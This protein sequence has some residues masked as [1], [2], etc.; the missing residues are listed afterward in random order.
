MAEAIEVLGPHHVLWDATGAAPVASIGYTFDG[1]TIGHEKFWERVV[2]D[3]YG[4]GTSRDAV[5]CGE[6][7]FIEFTLHQVLRS[8]F[9][10]LCF[11]DGTAGTLPTIG[12]LAS[13]LDGTNP[14]QLSFVSEAAS[15]STKHYT[16][17]RFIPL[18]IVQELSHRHTKATVRGEALLGGSDIFWNQTVGTP[19]G[20]SIV[21]VNGATHFQFPGSV[22][23]GYSEGGARLTY[24]YEW[25]LI[26]TD[27]KGGNTHRDAVFQGMSMEIEPIGDILYFDRAEVDDAEWHEPAGAMTAATLGEIG[28]KASTSAAVLNLTGPS[29]GFH[30]WAF[31]N[32]RLVGRID[33]R[34]S[35][36]ATRISCRWEAFPHGSTTKRF[37]VRTTI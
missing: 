1:A 32:A 26:S 11:N 36:K 3:Q 19:S 5:F 30:S 4:A 28:V 8:N 34:V 9:E 18:E 29:T 17:K 14:G 7:V 24:R 37:Y 31:D 16:F 2:T 13:T 35:S 12:A 22:D 10:L 27:D 21:E 23:L 20:S 6:Q 25:D 15:P 33:T